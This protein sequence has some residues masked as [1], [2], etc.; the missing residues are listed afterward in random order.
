ML[1]HTENCDGDK[2]IDCDKNSD[3]YSRGQNVSRELGDVF[4]GVAEK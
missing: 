4:G 1:E 2:H 3:K